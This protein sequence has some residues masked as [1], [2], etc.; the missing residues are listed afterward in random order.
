MTEQQQIRNTL[1]AEYL[2]KNASIML[3]DLDQ[4][5]NIS[6]ANSHA[7]K[8]LGE[9][10]LGTFV[11]RHLVDFRGSFSLE[12]L[13]THKDKGLLSFSLS[14]GV[15]TSLQVTFIPFGSCGFLLGEHDEQEALELQNTLIRLNS[16]L[17]NVSRE[18]QKKTI[19]LQQANNLKNQF[20]GIAAH[21][22]RS[23][24]A[25]VYAYIELLKED[26]LSTKETAIIEPLIEINREVDFMLNMVSNL[27]DYSVIEQ[28]HLELDFQQVNLRDL[29]GQVVQMQSL[30]AKTRNII[31][32]LDVLNDPGNVRIDV[33]RIRQVLNNLTNNAI[34]FSLPGSLVVLRLESDGKKTTVS[35]QDSGPGIPPD[36]IDKLFKPFGKTH[37]KAASGEKSTGL[38]LSI[39]RKI[40]ESH[41]GKIWIESPSSQGACFKFTLPIQSQYY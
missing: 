39:C 30:L 9:E 41:G 38:G 10:C 34:K 32:T 3:L 27:L 11:G 40:I 26:L 7:I 24:L 19:Q 25:S 20:L 16:D 37:H 4:H 22:L 14:N 31:I 18:L 15:P 2:D 36:E 35:V 5:G 6:K 13:K 28:G 17:N 29:I 8:L 33:N 1:L 21:D 23:P 12:Q